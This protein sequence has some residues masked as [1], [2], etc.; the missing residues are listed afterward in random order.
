MLLAKIAIDV[1]L[2]AL[3]RIFGLLHLDINLAAGKTVLPH[4]PR[5]GCGSPPRGTA[6]PRS[7]SAGATTRTVSSPH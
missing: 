2:E 1:T 6:T 5:Q 3:F 4:V 7:A